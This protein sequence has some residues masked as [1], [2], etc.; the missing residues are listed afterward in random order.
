MKAKHI[1]FWRYLFKTQASGK[2]FKISPFLK[3]YCELQMLEK[4]ILIYKALIIKEEIF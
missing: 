2:G 1:H 4:H 3:Y